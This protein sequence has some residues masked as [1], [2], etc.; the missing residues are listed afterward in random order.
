MKM[1]FFVLSFFFFAS[2]ECIIIIILLYL[3][4][5]S[6]TQQNCGMMGCLCTA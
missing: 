5:Q 4:K 1:I 3:G 6:L 2:V